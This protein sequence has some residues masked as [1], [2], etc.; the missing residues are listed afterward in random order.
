MES[1]FISG[2]A[3]NYDR[4]IAIIINFQVNAFEV[5]IVNDMN[6]HVKKA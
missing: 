5:E 1:M 2:N 4:L 6:S 3:I